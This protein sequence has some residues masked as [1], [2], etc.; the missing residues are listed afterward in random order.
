[1]Q[2]PPNFLFI[3]TDQ[4]RADYLGCA[5]HPVLKTPHIDAIA[6]N[7]TRFENF[8]VA[9]PV[10]MPNRASLLTGRYPSAHGLR[11]NGCELSYDASTFVEALRASGYR[12]AAIGKSHV[13]PM[14]DFP[15]EPR[16]D[17]DSLGPIKEA[18]KSDGKDYT[19]EEPARYETADYH[20][21][22][23]PYYGFDHVDMVT[24]HGDLCSG[25]Y[26]QWLRKSSPLADFWRDRKNQ[27][28]HNFICPQAIRTPMPEEFYPTSFIRDRAIDWLDGVKAD[29]KPFYAFVSFPDPHHPFTPPGKYWGMHDPED[30]EAPPGFEQHRNPIPPMRVLHDQWKDGKRA[31][32]AQEAFMVNEREAREAMAL[33]CG[34]I[35]MID[36]A[37]GAIIEK[38]RETGRYE[39]T[40]IIFNADHGDY[41]GDCGLLLKGAVMR[42]SIN[43]VPFI[44]SDPNDR[45]AAG[46]GAKVSG[47]K[48]SG[49][50][51]S[52]VDL[53]PSILERAGVK[54]YYGIQGRSFIGCLGG[55]A[56]LRDQLVI[57]HED[58]QTRAGFKK[59]AV[60]RT[61]LTKTRRLTI[62]RGETWGELYDLEADPLEMNNRWD[63]SEYAA[64]RARLTE[65]LMREMLDNVDASPR[66]RRRA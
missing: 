54:P 31:D 44:W 52:T 62:Y 63:D 21:F 19:H 34:M 43:N 7:G 24:W 6:A 64:E 8:N 26:L 47:A 22:D 28:P 12:T 11:H 5:G 60:A 27:L 33:T 32:K 18:W 3:I 48:V 51:A 35:S 50:L 65:A 36:D 37:V 38:L 49:A 1:M 59:P 39:N 13:Q 61:L 16:A 4:H 14:T 10:C 17:P 23:L 2:K 53:A 55:S 9:T 42:R 57:E 30:F 15:A 20:K 58:T 41:L 40:V 56:A 25:H 45:A 46:S 29:D 66:A